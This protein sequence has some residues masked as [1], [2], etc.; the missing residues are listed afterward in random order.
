MRLGTVG[1]AAGVACLIG[2]GSADGQTWRSGTTTRQLHGEQSLQVTVELAAGT[3]LLRPGDPAMLYRS[4]VRY[5]ADVFT[6]STTFDATRSRL[7][8]ALKPSG[9]RGDWDLGD[10]P[11]QRLD[12]ALSPAVPA[13][14]DLR[15]GAATADLELGG[16]SLAHATVQTGASNSVISF[17]APNRIGCSRFELEA[18]AAEV[19]LSGLGNSRCDHITVTGGVGEV[20]LDFTGNWLEP[21]GADVEVTIGLGTLLLRFPEGLGVAID[22]DRFL[23]SFENRS[24]VK[25]G[26]RYVSAGFEEAHARVELHLK[27]VFGDVKVEWV[28]AAAR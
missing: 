17:G 1:V 22:V 19:E 16:L 27:A 11:D 26:S 3:F 20:R 10:Q 8:V 6:S 23:A 21:S 2:V 4:N 7:D 25:H 13:R 5:D 28:P 24:F 9:E 18:G 15:F 12:L 14:L